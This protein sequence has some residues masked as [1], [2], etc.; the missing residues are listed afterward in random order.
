[1]VDDRGVG[2]ALPLQLRELIRVKQRGVQ[3]GQLSE[4][5]LAI[6]RGLSIEERHLLAGKHWSMGKI[7]D[8][9]V[10]CGPVS[11]CQIQVDNYV[12]SV[13]LERV[14]TDEPD[15]VRRSVQRHIANA[16]SCTSLF[17]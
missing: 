2:R 9:R 16:G 7:H 5:D 17:K 12:R 3:S 1:M 14:S 10:F 11:C 8:G 15:L 4:C 6:G 13:G